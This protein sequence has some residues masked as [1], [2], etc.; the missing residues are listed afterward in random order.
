MELQTHI[1]FTPEEAQIDYASKVLLLGSCFTENIGAKLD[2]FKFQHLQNPFGIVFHPLAI[3][4]L[5][6][7]AVHDNTFNGEDV[8]ERDGQWYCFEAHSSVTASS[9]ESLVNLLNERL[10]ELSSYLADAS[11]IVITLGTAWVYKHL[12]LNTA[13][14]NC[15]KIPQRHFTKELLTV[16]EISTSIEKSIQLIRTHNPTATLIKTVSPVRH[17]KDGLV[18]NSRGKAHL[19]AAVQAVVQRSENGFYFPS[20]ELMMD[21]LRDY[22]FYADDMLH[23][24]TTAIQYI[25]QRFKKVWIST[26]T[27]TL[28]K[29]IGSIQAGLRHRPFNVNGKEYQK[30]QQQLRRAIE[31]VRQEL[32]HVTF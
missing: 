26:E 30:F 5:V 2:Y 7:R 32:P 18:E 4:T 23:P 9:K 25:W 13:V 11:H 12:E 3:E 15:H 1:A 10:H 21:E 19:L 8:F 6:T 17:I 20:Y 29:K 16:E 24:N 31:L 28:Q 27:E 22:R 14:A